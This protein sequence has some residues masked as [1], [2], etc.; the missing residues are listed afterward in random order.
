MKV[1][2]CF[3]RAFIFVI[4]YSSCTKFELDEAERDVQVIEKIIEDM[5]EVDPPYRPDE[6]CKRPYIEENIILE[7]L[8]KRIESLS[9]V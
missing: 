3:M 8:T 7:S 1:L 2:I 5:R 4:A 9:I 6:R